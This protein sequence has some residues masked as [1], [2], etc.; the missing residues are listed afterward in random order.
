[1]DLKKEWKTT[2]RPEGPTG[3]KK[4]GTFRDISLTRLPPEDIDEIDSECM[5]LGMKRS[6]YMES[7]YG[8]DIERIRER[9]RGWNSMVES[10]IS[11]REI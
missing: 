2:D 3:R 7:L 1:M 11:R 5:R 8:D 6:E 9:I 4:S 10:I